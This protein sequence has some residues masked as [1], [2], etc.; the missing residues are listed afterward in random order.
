[1]KDDFLKSRSSSG[2]N[3]DTLRKKIHNRLREMRGAESGRS[4]A[5]RCGIMSQSLSK[6]ERE[7]G[8]LPGAEMLRAMC[9]AAGVSADWVLCLTD[10]R[11]GFSATPQ[12][13]A[14]A[15][16]N[17]PHAT[18][19]ADAG[20][21]SILADALARVAALPRSIPPPEERSL[22]DVVRRVGAMEE[23]VRALAAAVGAS[24]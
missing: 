16:A 9:V 14:T 11:R 3:E 10:E 22:A 17:A 18:A 21:A 12:N 8:P 5:R 19:I 2:E 1:M 23:A 4:F 6:Y 15:S 20:A 13:V 7:D 24:R